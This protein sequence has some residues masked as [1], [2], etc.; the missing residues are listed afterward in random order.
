MPGGPA[1]QRTRVRDLREIRAPRALRTG[2]VIV[3]G[4]VC[5][6]GVVLSCY[7]GVVVSGTM[8]QHPKLC[9]ETR[10]GAFLLCRWAGVVVGIVVGHWHIWVLRK[11]SEGARKGDA[12]LIVQGVQGKS[13]EGTHQQKVV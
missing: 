3:S 9:S 2:V 13:K 8:G 12:L 4:A 10:L 7:G 5:N 6:S 11:C 1:V